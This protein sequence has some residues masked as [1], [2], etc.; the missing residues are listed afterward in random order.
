M[1]CATA[2]I[3]AGHRTFTTGGTP[4]PRISMAEQRDL[5]TLAGSSPHPVPTS[6]ARFRM[7]PRE[8]QRRSSTIATLIHRLPRMRIQIAIARAISNTRAIEKMRIWCSFAHT[9]DADAFGARNGSP[10]KSN[11]MRKMLKD[12]SR[13]KWK[14]LRGRGFRVEGTG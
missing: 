7:S 11:S 5:C 6:I 14:G 2:G 12:W 8:C 3:R 9:G 10:S 13:K 4:G 1:A